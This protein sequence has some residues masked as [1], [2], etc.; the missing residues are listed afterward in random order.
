M[1]VIGAYV[2]WKHGYQNEPELAVMVDKLHDQ[3]V[4]KYDKKEIDG[5]TAYYAQTK[6]GWVNFLIHNP[7]NNRG[8]RGSMFNIT[9]T[10]DKKVSI[11]GPWSSRSGVMNALGFEPCV[12]IT[13]DDISE[14]IGILYAGCIAIWKAKEIVK[15]FLPGI[16]LKLED[17]YG[18]PTYK[19]VLED[20][21][22]LCK[23][24]KKPNDDPK[25]QKCTACR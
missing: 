12:E 18:E 5:Y 1:K 13:T 15:K 16:Y 10:N 9:M 21:L 22:Q 11:K 2:D 14:K 17:G 19:I 8:F 4:Y 23:G 20:N 3:S 24:C 6:E 25:N 7:D